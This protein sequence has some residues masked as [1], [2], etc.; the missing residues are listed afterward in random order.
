MAEN[1]ITTTPTPIL[2][3]PPH[4]PHQHSK[5][6]QFTAIALPIMILTWIIAIIVLCV[7]WLK[8]RTMRAQQRA[9]AEAEAQAGEFLH[10]H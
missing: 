3:Q 9:E 1:A 7:T 4:E 2:T 10:P 8:V 5:R 6:D